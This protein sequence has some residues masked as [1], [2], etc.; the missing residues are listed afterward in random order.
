VCCALADGP[1]C[2][3]CRVAPELR[4]LDGE[5][6]A[7]AAY[8]AAAGVPVDA[9]R[10]AVEAA[11]LT[12][13]VQR[14]LARSMWTRRRDVALAGASEADV[15]R[16]MQ[17]ADPLARAWALPAPDRRHG[18]WLSG[19]EVQVALASRVGAPVLR[20][21]PACGCRVDRAAWDYHG[22][23][24][25]H[26]GGPALAHT[27]LKLG[28][29]HAARMLGFDAHL[30]PMDA[31]PAAQPNAHPADVSIARDGGY[32]D[33]VDVT[34][35][36][37]GASDAVGSL[38]AFYNARAAEKLRTYN[39]QALLARGFEYKVLVVGAPLGDA[40]IGT[41]RYLADLACEASRRRGLP[42]PAVRAALYAS[43]SLSAVRGLAARYARADP[44]DFD[45]GGTGC[46]GFF[47]GGRP[48]VPILRAPPE[49]R[50]PPFP[51]RVPSERRARTQSAELGRARCARSRFGSPPRAAVV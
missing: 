13:H 31:A 18:T 8:A 43:L 39:L 28:M 38:A 51:A 41:H 11:A 25:R 30:E 6:A 47:R 14:S 48:G 34:Q 22:R 26:M 44:Y 50:D 9:A 27:R 46:R 16:V 21:P 40:S 42:L 36:D 1:P 20:R 19:P 17:A 29:Y 15:L 4:Y 10:R 12:R 49:G 45:P 35:A 24:C 33:A 3:A 5:D 2:A 37:I 23:S 7:L 32:R